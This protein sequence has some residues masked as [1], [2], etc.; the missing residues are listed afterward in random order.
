MSNSL[1]QR[2][3]RHHL[4]R[5]VHTNADPPM[6]TLDLRADALAHPRRRTLPT[7]K[8]LFVCVLAQNQDHQ[9]R[10]LAPRA[11]PPFPTHAPH[12]PAHTPTHTHTA[13]CHPCTITHFSS[14]CP[15]DSHPPCKKHVHTPTNPFACKLTHLACPPTRQHNF[16]IRF[17]IY[18]VVVTR[19]FEAMRRSILGITSVTI[20]CSSGTKF[21]SLACCS[22]DTH[23]TCCSSE[24][25]YHIQLT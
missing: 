15:S 10:S 24:K 3:S 2:V 23:L 5:R 17:I 25:P 14:T 18:S 13:P 8:N 1:P 12:L 22:S 9:C 16:D 19:K 4:A 11:Y 20:L 6:P 21:L 7:C